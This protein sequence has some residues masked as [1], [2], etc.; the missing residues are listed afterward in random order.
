M[1]II[2]SDTNTHFRGAENYRR[3]GEVDAMRIPKD[4]FFAHQVMWDGWVDVEKP[5]AHILGHWNYAPGVKKN[6]SVVSSAHAV[7]LFLDGKSLGRGEPGSG[8]LHT[9]RG[10]TWEPGTLAAVGYD[11]QGAKI[12]E[13]SHVT[14]GEPAAIKLTLHTAPAGLRADAADLALVQFEVV[15]AQGRRCPTA[16]NP[17]DFELT[18]PAEWRGGIAQGPGNFILA[19]S[20]PV[21]CGVNRV[22]LRSTTV[23]G[24]IVLTAR[25][26]GLASA[27]L[28]LTSSAV[29]TTDGW[30]LTHPG[31]GL[32]GRLDL[33]PTP[34]GPSFTPSRRSVTIA[35][36]TAG[37][38]AAEAG[39]SFDDNEITA[40][41]SSDDVAQAWIE[42]RFDGPADVNNATFKLTGWRER[43]YPIRILIEGQEVW[44]GVTT[45]SLGYV[46][47]PFKTTRGQTV[48]LELVGASTS[49]DAFN[50]TEL[51]DQANAATGS[52]RVL[53]RS[54]SIIEAEFYEP[55]ASR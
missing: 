30:S 23:P 5:R 31:D 13:A 14:A 40:W 39:L 34:A 36:V 41:T 44:R 45:R 48:R 53:A 25:S 35:S 27:Q 17:V 43:T 38:N 29:T 49:D 46:T 37:S 24:K 51:A 2:F 26:A 6:V 33:G 42:Y 47:I 18:G 8:F 12:C 50:L 16:L 15:D 20:L 11:A 3:S 28:E 22:L 1:N 54:L 4:G 32:T 55:A 9:F 19:R 52:N 10:V 21:E 7:E